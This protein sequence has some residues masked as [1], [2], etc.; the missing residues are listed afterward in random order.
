MRPGYRLRRP[1]LRISAWGPLLI[2]LT[3]FALVGI[4]E[5]V[6]DLRLGVTEPLSAALALAALWP[7]RVLAVTP[8]SLRFRG[9]SFPLWESAA[10]RRAPARLREVGWADVVEILLAAEPHRLT[11][12]IGFRDPGGPSAGLSATVLELPASEEPAIV[13]A[14]SAAAPDVTVR[15]GR[16]AE[17]I[18]RTR[19]PYLVQGRAPRTWLLMGAV[20]G[21]AVAGMVTLTVCLAEVPRLSNAQSVLGVVLLQL[22]T[23]RPAL[24]ICEERLVLSGWWQHRVVPWTTI[25]SVRLS[26]TGDSTELTVWLGRPLGRS[27][28]GRALTYR[29]PPR[30]DLGDIDAMIRAY[31]PPYAL[32]AAG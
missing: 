31:A 19:Q 14:I 24:I 23:R 25:E 20:T 30:A 8:R 13:A 18:A 16:R 7:V 32:A 27:L 21:L 5:D 29:L 2:V 28:A 26:T 4:F 1:R 12:I 22:W 10:R 9:R 17:I 11:M 6:H 15:R 3:V